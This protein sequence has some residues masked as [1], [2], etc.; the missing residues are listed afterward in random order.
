[1][2]KVHQFLR[3]TSYYYYFIKHFAQIAIPLQDLL[4]KDDEAL[5]IKKK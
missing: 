3:L 2:Y 4:Y 1:M 5:Y